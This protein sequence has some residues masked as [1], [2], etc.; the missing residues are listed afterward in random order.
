MRENE[1]RDVLQ[2]WR[3]SGQLPTGLYDPSPYCFVR[4]WPLNDEATN[5]GKN[6]VG[7]QQFLQVI[8]RERECRQFVP[9]QQGYSPKEH[10]EMQREELLMNWQAEQRD[11]DRR[12]Q[13]EQ[14]DRDMDRQKQQRVEDL[15]REEKKRNSDRRWQVGMILLAAVVGLLFSWISGKIN[16]KP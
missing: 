9:W 14:R 2:N 6:S 5:G 4:A 1:L 8:Q 11:T 12:W 16:G 7:P 13:Q 3:D 10:R 15:D